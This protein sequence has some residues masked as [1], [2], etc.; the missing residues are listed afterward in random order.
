[1]HWTEGRVLLEGKLE[2]IEEFI[3]RFPSVTEVMIYGT[4]RLI[5]RPQDQ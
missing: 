2:A 3:I 5:Q 1:M 4:E